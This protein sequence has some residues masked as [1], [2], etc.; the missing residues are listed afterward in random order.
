[1][2]DF[3]TIS[4]TILHIHCLFIFIAGMFLRALVGELFPFQNLLRLS[5]TNLKKGQWQIET[6]LNTA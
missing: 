6:A 2:L 5:I 3:F 1:V 4:F